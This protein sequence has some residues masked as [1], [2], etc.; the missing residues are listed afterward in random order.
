MSDW[1]QRVGLVVTLVGSVGCCVLGS[2]S[3]LAE[4]EVSRS[5]GKPNFLVIFTDD[6]C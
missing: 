5:K 2:E 6:K 1:R 4:A 3:L